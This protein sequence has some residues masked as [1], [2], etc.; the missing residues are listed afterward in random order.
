MLHLQLTIYYTASVQVQKNILITTDTFNLFLFPGHYSQMFSMLLEH[1][2]HHSMFIY[3]QFISTRPRQSQP[4]KSTKFYFIC[5]YNIYESCRF[6]LSL[7]MVVFTFK[8]KG[9]RT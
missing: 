7:T 4:T 2:V 3:E 8:S 9:L 1:A 6:T 5:I